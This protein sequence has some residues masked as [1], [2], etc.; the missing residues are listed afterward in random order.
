MAGRGDGPIARSKYKEG[1][2]LVHI[3]PSFMMLTRHCRQ[4]DW[5][6]WLPCVTNLQLI[7]INASTQ[8]HFL[9]G[10]GNL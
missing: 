9:S 2:A 10:S 6:S 7:M 5:N 3:R 8:L 4:N 1:I